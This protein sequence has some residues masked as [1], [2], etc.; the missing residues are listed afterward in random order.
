M[1]RLDTFPTI[2]LV[3]SYRNVFSGVEG[4]KVL[5]HILYELGLFQEVSYSPE[6]QALKNYG[7]RLL[8]I[9]GGGDVGMTA[10]TMLSRQLM[11]QPLE[12]AKNDR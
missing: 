10:V 1:N 2:E 7:S 4:P 3:K 11:S 12:K 9:L 6:D 5:A 8:S